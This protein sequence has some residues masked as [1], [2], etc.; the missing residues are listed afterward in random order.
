MDCISDM[1]SL[2]TVGAAAVV[3]WDFKLRVIVARD[4]HG[5]VFALWRP[6]SIVSL[7]ATVQY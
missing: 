3:H 2:E 6:H 7:Q 4:E 1:S 5:V